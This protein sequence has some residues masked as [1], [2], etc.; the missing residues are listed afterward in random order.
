[1]YEGAGK[2]NSGET[3]NPRVRGSIPRL[4]TI[5]KI[6]SNTWKAIIRKRGWPTTIKTFRSKRDAEDRAR[7]T[8]DDRVRGVY[9]DCADSD[10]FD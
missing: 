9:I 4:A 1:M 7:S 6:P 2:S 5:T 10:S 8:E 3:E